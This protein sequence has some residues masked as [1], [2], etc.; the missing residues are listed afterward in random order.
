MNRRKFSQCPRRG[1]EFSSESDCLWPKAE[2]LLR[3]RPTGRA[4]SLL[5]TRCGRLERRWRFPEAAIHWQSSKSGIDR[6]LGNDNLSQMA[7]QLRSM[8]RAAMKPETREPRNATTL[9]AIKGVVL[10]SP[11]TTASLQESARG[12]RRTTAPIRALSSARSSPTSS[13]HAMRRSFSSLVNETSAAKPRLVGLI[14]I[15]VASIAGKVRIMISSRYDEWRFHR[16]EGR[17]SRTY[18]R[19]K[20]GTSGLFLVFLKPFA[21]QF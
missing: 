13:L 9:I 11:T 5:S 20:R 14:D 2:R 6:M 16:I 12:M 4:D 1:F 7:D 15:T 8:L 3:R 17:K 19:C 10:R 21:A 18:R